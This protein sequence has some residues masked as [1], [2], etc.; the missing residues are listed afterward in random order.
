MLIDRK[1]IVSLTDLN[2]FFKSK[3]LLVLV[4]NVVWCCKGMEHFLMML[5]VS[6]KIVESCKAN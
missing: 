5:V 1:E 4:T 2:L 6:T 3:M